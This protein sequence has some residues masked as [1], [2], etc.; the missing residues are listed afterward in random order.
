MHKRNIGLE[1]E[2]AAETLEL[3]QARKAL[4]AACSVRN[5]DAAQEG[6]LNFM[7]KAVQGGGPNRKYAQTLLSEQH[8]LF[9]YVLRQY[10]RRAYCKHSRIVRPYVRGPAGEIGQHLQGPGY[11][12][13]TALAAPGQRSAAAARISRHDKT[14]QQKPPSHDVDILHCFIN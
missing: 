7:R 11:N 9:E 6:Y 1:K 4:T 5:G 2:E 12:N 13:S 8:A 14:T 3:I 10:V